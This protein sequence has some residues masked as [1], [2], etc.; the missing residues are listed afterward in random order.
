M[1]FVVLS[2]E[3]LS[4]AVKKPFNVIAT[5]PSRGGTS[6]FGSLL[7]E[8]GFYLGKRPH[9]VTFENLDFVDIAH[10]ERIWDVRWRLLIEELN[11]EAPDWALKLPHAMRRPDLLDRHAPNPI[12]FVMVRNVLPTIKSLMKYDET[13][14]DT[15]FD[16]RRGFEHFNYFFTPF[17]YNLPALS[18]PVVL[19][20]YE[21]AMADLQ[22]FIGNFCRLLAMPKT[23]EEIGAIELKMRRH[24]QQYKITEKHE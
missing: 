14:E 24:H 21:L 12:F 3:K 15:L 9:P 18:A 23:P 16:F 13:Y 8:L 20:N 11:Q 22:N 1:P 2:A 19:C 5:G 10:E 6:L 7:H 17:F 4:K